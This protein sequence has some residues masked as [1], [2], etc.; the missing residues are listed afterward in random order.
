[1]AKWS[2]CVVA[3][4]FHSLANHHTYHK[5]RRSIPKGFPFHNERS[6][7]GLGNECPTLIISPSILQQ[8]NP[9]QLKNSPRYPTTSSADT[10]IVSSKTRVLDRSYMIIPLCGQPWYSFSPFAPPLLQQRMTRGN[11][12]KPASRDSGSLR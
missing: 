1:M 8:K 2:S 10:T 9:T 3:S 6:A 7:A 11:T 4:I 12:A 5:D